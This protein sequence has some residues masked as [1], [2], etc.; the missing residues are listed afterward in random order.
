MDKEIKNISIII[1]VYNVESYIEKCIDSILNQSYVSFELI[2]VDDGSIDNSGLICDRYANIDSRVK[3]FHVSNGGVSSARNKGIEEASSDWLFFIDSD[4]WVD[5]EYLEQLIK[6]IKSETSIC[7]SGVINEY[8]QSERKTTAF[9]YPNVY[10]DSIDNLGVFIAKYSILQNGLPYAKMFNKRI[11][12]QY[13]IRFDTSL[14]FHEDHLFV[15]QYLMHVS[16]FATTDIMSYHY[17]HEENK[18]SLSSKKH[19]PLKIYEAGVKMLKQTKILLQQYHIENIAYKKRAYT[20]VALCHIAIA[21]LQSDKTNEDVLLNSI[22][23]FKQ[24]FIQYYTPNSNV[25]KYLILATLKC[26]LRYGR[27]ILLKL[28]RIL[29]KKKYN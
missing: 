21:L 17:R 6:N 12:N 15:F 1:P 16:D 18:M 10:C 19:N 11:L 7:Y 14:S 29:Y 24:D 8:I 2:L 28:S 9:S 13:N 4:D 23:E 20:D 3:V 22:L 5:P 27:I 25:A 26:P